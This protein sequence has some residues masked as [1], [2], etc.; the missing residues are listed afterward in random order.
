MKEEIQ[1][2]L[3]LWAPQT[4]QEAVNLA[5]FQESLINDRLLVETVDMKSEMGLKELLQA[6]T[7]ISATTI[8][9]VAEFSSK[10]YRGEEQIVVKEITSTVL[11]NMEVIAEAF[12]D[13]SNCP[14]K[15]NKFSV[16]SFRLSQFFYM[17]V[18]VYCV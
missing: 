2:A 14:I 8:I 16:D 15:L 9:C 11:N 6:N 13:K 1:E 3:E 4:L 17:Y 18:C 12:L 5:R 10:S 7:E